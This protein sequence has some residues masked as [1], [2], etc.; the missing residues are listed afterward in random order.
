MLYASHIFI[1]LLIPEQGGVFTNSHSLGLHGYM[2]K[3]KK[4]KRIHREL[5]E[6]PMLSESQLC[7]FYGGGEYSRNPPNEDGDTPA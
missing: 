4:Q 5:S 7:S 3:H 2:M 6:D 1:Y